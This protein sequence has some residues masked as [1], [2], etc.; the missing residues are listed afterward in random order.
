MYM[1]V[2]FTRELSAEESGAACGVKLDGC[3]GTA[4][5][6][7]CFEDGSGVYVCQNCFNRR[8]NEGEWITDGAGELLA[9]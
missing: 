9:S 7:V 6:H 3:L 5:I 4:S 1:E 2:K 8:V